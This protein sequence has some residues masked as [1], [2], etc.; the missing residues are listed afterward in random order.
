MNNKLIVYVLDG[1][2]RCQAL[3]TSLSEQNIKYQEVS[4]D[5]DRNSITCDNLESE[6]DCR[7]YPIIEIKKRVEK[8]KGGYFVFVD[9]TLA[10][11][12]C[13]KYDDLAVRRKIK[14]GYFAICTRSPSEMI[15]EL[16]KNI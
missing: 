13:T 15:Q 12:S 14:D 3:K 5:S 9:E 2:K 10:I 16:I 1:C 8:D 11:H 4:C 7:Y 6:L